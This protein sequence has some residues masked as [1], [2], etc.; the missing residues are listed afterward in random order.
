MITSTLRY[1]KTFM[2]ELFNYFI[3]IPDYIHKLC[4]KMVF[5]IHDQKI[6]FHDI[7]TTN[8][9][10]GKHHLFRGRIS[11]AL[12][13]FRAAHFLFD[14]QNKEINYWLGW[15]HFY[16]SNYDEA[17]AY[18]EDSKEYDTDHLIKFIKT[19]NTTNTVPEALWTRINR[20][21]IAE[22]DNRY[23]IHIKGKYIDIPLEF[24][25]LCMN[26]LKDVKHG[27]EILDYGCGSGFV[28]SMI[29]HTISSDYKITAIE[30]L[31][32]F[33]YY[34]K[35]LTG[36]RG[37]IYDKII[38]KSLYDTHKTLI[39]KKYDL[40]TSFDSLIFTKDLSSHLKSFHKALSK[41]GH[42]AIYLPLSTKTEWSK[43]NKSFVFDESDIENQLRLAEFNIIAIK[44][45]KLDANKSFIGLIC[46]K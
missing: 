20:I 19:C 23:H 7:L 22:H 38:E 39:A 3:N 4:T 15:C 34:A 26:N 2:L 24:V 13:R 10:L 5:F 40:I 9:E 44:K 41:N 32:L 46:I 8:I 29:D 30:N 31:D 16:K 1:V 25:Q 36:D 27:T 45:W 21:R 37:K 42:L 28:G 12:F 6:K 11:D 18:L 35:Q 33:V 43:N 14:T 17:I